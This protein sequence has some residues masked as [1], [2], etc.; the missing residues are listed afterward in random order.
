MR[1]SYCL[2]ARVPGCECG[3]DVQD[4]LP[5]L[6]QCRIIAT[7]EIVSAITQTDRDEQER[8]EKLQEAIAHALDFSEAYAS[9]ERAEKLLE[10]ARKKATKS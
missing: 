3:E 10:E 6:P 8:D 7:G 1:L 9:L 5:D 2:L 4:L